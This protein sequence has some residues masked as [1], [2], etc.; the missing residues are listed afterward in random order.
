MGTNPVNTAMSRNHQ[1]V[2]SA[3]LIGAL[4][5]GSR[6]LGLIRETGF[7]HFFGASPLFSAYRVAFQIP[8]L[9]RRLFGEGA[10]TSSFI[11]VF[12]RTLET[13]GD[14]QGK[15]LAG[16]VF[17]LL[18]T[19]LIGLLVLIETGLLVASFF[20]QGPTLTLSAITMPYMVFICVTAFFGG[21]LN[22]LHRF[23]APAIA[24][25]L[26]NVVSISAIWIGGSILHLQTYT[27]LILISC[28][29]LV[30]GVLQLGLQLAWLRSCNFTIR[31]NWG[32]SSPAVQRI[33]RLMMPMIIGMSAVQLNTFADTLIALFL[34]EDGRGPAILGYAQYVSHLP[35][36]IFGTALATAI[37]PLLAKR[38]AEKDTAGFKQVVEMGLRTSLFI[39]IPAGV[40]LILVADPLIQIGRAH[41]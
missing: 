13:E 1:F 12:T 21:V 25:I 36:G 39:A 31:V 17:T 26:L 34:V 16:A 9:A 29:V 19:I 41:V 3:K 8:N 27:H 2:G 14:L 20:V 37:F 28:S 10:L 22:G 7:S 35:L 30:S 15:Q 33:V 32:W 38:V 24:P 4:T 23:A 18:T 11:P 40:G 6:I 5:L